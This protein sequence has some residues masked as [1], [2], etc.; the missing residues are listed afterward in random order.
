MVSALCACVI[1]E[2]NKQARED[3]IKRQKQ[4]DA[5]IAAAVESSEK[6]LKVIY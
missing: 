2:Y 1:Q 6:T 3:S 5:L 4:Q